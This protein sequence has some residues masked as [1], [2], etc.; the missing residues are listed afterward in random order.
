L[1][2]SE[3]I[4]RAMEMQREQR[5]DEAAA[6]YED[7]LGKEPENQHALHFYGVLHYQR[8]ERERA[9]ELIRRSLEIDATQAGAHTNLG[10]I[11]KAMGEEQQALESYQAA[12]GIDPGHADA[13]CNAGVLLRNHGR[14]NEAHDVLHR[15]IVLDPA[16]GEAWHNL[17]LCYLL[18]GQHEKAADAF[19]RCYDSGAAGDWSDPTWHARVLCALGREAKARE[20]LEGQIARRPDDAIARHQLAALSGETPERASDEYVRRHFNSFSASFDSVLENLKYR[21][22][23]IVAARV[24]RY[25]AGRPKVPDVV[26]LG[27][28]TGLCGRLVGKFCARLTGVDISPGML[29]RAGR[30]GCYHYLVESELTFFLDDAPEHCFDMALSVDT[31][32]YFGALDR[33]FAG[34]ARALKPGGIFVATVERL[35]GDEAPGFRIDPSGRYCHA[36][37]YLRATAAAVGL[38]VVAVEPEELRKELGKPVNGLVFTLQNNAASR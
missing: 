23:E 8:G 2:H 10:N 30:H 33:V 32:C 28:G 5:L 11:L 31:L 6:T 37:S 4:H 25:C 15:A 18:M 38:S 29:Q 20:I 19:Q 13:W 17:G 12:I 14:I 16:L 35:E 22:P 24:E 36:E 27:C 1:D 21:A 9:V 7:V 26:D 3:A 34:L